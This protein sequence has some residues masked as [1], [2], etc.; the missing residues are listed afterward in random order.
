MTEPNLINIY[1]FDHPE[2]YEAVQR[3]KSRYE[4]EVKFLM[5]VFQKQGEGVRKV[6]DIGCGTG[7][8][9]DYL[10]KEG[11]EGVGVDLNQHMVQY[12]REHYFGID[13]KVADMRQLEYKDDFDALFSLC[14]TFSWNR[15]NEEV[16]SALQSFHRSVRTG[17]LVVI[18]TFNPIVF[19]GNKKFKKSIVNRE[20]YDQFG[21]Y[22]V[23][24]HRVNNEEQ[25]M[26][27]RR[28]IRSIEDDSVVKED[29]LE[30]RLFFPQE[31]RYFLETNGFQLLSQHSSFDLENTD[32]DEFR[33]ITVSRKI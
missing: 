5:D 8:H 10:R 28:T 9:L 2:L 21:F 19:I 11:I 29:E 12:A 26:Y 22:C 17:G 15:T 7:L 25:R 30:Y 6:L 1:Y 32:L 13:F 14:T 18:E 3:S 27:E 24:D 4:T 23:L 31:M 16:V 20:P 33:L